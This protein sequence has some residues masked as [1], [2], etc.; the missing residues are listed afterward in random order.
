LRLNDLLIIGIPGEMTAEIGKKL[1]DQVAEKTGVKHPIIGGLANEWISY[2]LSPEQYN[3]GGGYEASVSFY[4]PQLGP[5]VMAAALKGA[6]KL[7]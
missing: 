2:I 4:G 3:G 7:E 6:E 5:T 1:R